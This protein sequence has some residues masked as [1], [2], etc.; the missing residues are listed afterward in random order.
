MPPPGAAPGPTDVLLRI[1]RPPLHGASGAATLGS[2]TSLV[3]ASASPRRAALLRSAGLDVQVRPVACDETPRPHETAV[4]YARRIAAAKLTAA[5]ADR[6]GPLPTLT[7]DTVVW[8]AR[9]ARPLGK[10]RDR[11]HARAG[12]RRLLGTDHFVTTAWALA[13]PSGEPSVAHETTRVWM[14]ALCDQELE[15]YLD[16]DEWHDKAGGYGIQG[17]AAGL[18]TRIEGSYTNVVGLP[19]AQVLQALGRGMPTAEPPAV[20][21]SR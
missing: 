15:R 19:L 16:T 5:L 10:P 14:R 9:T 3:L 20:E 1:L 17:H 11:E 4:A 6:S 2:V 18:V 12:L 7:A 8:R 13:W 21:P